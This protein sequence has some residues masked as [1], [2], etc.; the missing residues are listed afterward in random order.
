MIPMV[1]TDMTNEE[2]WDAAFSLAPILKD[3]TVVTQ[4]IPIDDG[5]TMAMIDG[6]SVLIPDLEVNSKYLADTL[7]SDEPSDA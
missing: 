3:L 7:G 1:T 5:H 6:M 4:R 2:I